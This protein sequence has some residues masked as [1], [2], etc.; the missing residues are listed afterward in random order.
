MTD[1]SMD[2]WASKSALPSWW[3]AAL[4]PLTSKPYDYSLIGSGNTGMMANWNTAAG[5]PLPNYITMGVPVDVAVTGIQD[6]DYQYSI[7]DMAETRMSPPPIGP[8]ATKE[9]GNGVTYIIIVTV[10]IVVAIIL[11]KIFKKKPAQMQYAPPQGD[12]Q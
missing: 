1:A 11:Y 9:S 5:M 4:L 10:V 3:N 12:G 8:V 6:F 2:L 7:T